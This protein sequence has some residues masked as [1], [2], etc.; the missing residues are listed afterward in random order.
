MKFTPSYLNFMRE[1]YLCSFK[2][3]EKQ[4]INKRK[5]TTKII[6]MENKLDAFQNQYMNYNLNYTVFTTKRSF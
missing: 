2:R 4:T 6:V 1:N 3:Y 5:I